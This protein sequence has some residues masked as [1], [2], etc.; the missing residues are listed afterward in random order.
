[1]SIRTPSAQPERGVVS[2]L[3]RMM[4]M[5]LR[6]LSEDPGNDRPAIRMLLRNAIRL[7]VSHLGKAE[8]AAITLETLQERGQ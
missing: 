7:G 6:K 2:I 8:A 4:K 3:P 5:A 1:M